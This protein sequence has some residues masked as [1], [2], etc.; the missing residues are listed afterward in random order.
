MNYL[1]DY[2][3]YEQIYHCDPEICVLRNRY[4]QLEQWLKDGNDPNDINQF[5]MPLL[6]LAARKTNSEITKL[7]LKYD[8]NPD[9][10]TKKG[11]TAL[12]YAIIDNG[13]QVAEELIKNGAN[14]DLE[15]NTKH[16]TALIYAASLKNY[17]ILHMLLDADADWTY[18]DRNGKSFLDKLPNT[19]REKIIKS[20]PEKY[21]H[22]L[23]FKGYKQQAK[24][25]KI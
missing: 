18:L 21:E 16:Y 15:T 24:K 8:A 4:E 5:G 23:K 1:K 25:F 20:Y 11:Y 9:I 2:K 12:I 10:Q 3:L 19:K 17:K 7:L 22:Y 6:S 14:L 13:V